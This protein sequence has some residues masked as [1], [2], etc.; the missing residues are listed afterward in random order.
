MA[1][2]KA[3]TPKEQALI[4][5]RVEF[6]QSKPNIPKARAR[7]QFFVQTRAAE[8]QSKG[9]EVTKQK[10]QEL[11]QKFQ[12]GEV[13]RSGFYTDA[14]RTRI[15]ASN[16]GKAGTSST[17]VT[18]TVN[19]G[20]NLAQYKMLGKENT[21]RRPVAAKKSS[22][23]GFL[24][25]AANLAKRGLE[26][27]A[28]APLI[29]FA[30][31]Q[32]NSGLE[33]TAATFINP[34]INLIGEGLNK[35]AFKKDGQKGGDYNPNLRVAGKMEAATNTVMAVADIFTAGATRSLR[36]ANPTFLTPPA[37]TGLI[38]KI[39]TK[40]DKLDNALASR[41][42]AKTAPVTTPKTTARPTGPVSSGVKP[43]KV[44]VTGPY[45]RPPVVQA[46]SVKPKATRTSSTA[47]PAA[48]KTQ[49]QMQKEADNAI[50]GGLSKVMN[51]APVTKGPDM[52]SSSLTFVEPKPASAAKPK[53]S[54]PFE[55]TDPINDPISFEKKQEIFSKMKST[56]SPKANTRKPSGPRPAPKTTRKKAEA[57]KNFNQKVKQVNSGPQRKIDP[58]IKKYKSQEDFDKFMNS[59]GKEVVVQATRANPE[60][61]RA[62]TE[63]NK[64]FIKTRSTR[65]TSQAAARKKRADRRT[66]AALRLNRIRANQAAKA[67]GN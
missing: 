40:I 17:P 44:N 15:A 49:A 64:E 4:K 51:E 10:R 39:N 34:S 16:S 24:S 61:G 54:K 19:T 62:F 38:T 65:S 30:T 20:Q 12:S 13:K 66:Q 6:V 35:L 3:K 25:G 14:D 7:Q 42:K 27:V 32:V 21:A 2:K 36:I 33:S 50:S 28:N 31:R 63:A 46:S 18:P 52:N 1:S 59:G 41:A 37:K 56:K 11:R 48:R 55:F 60:V 43:S 47:K 8:L 53:A 26:D 23:G 5:K 57:G 58:K 67:A 29:K 45:S 22:G 9:V